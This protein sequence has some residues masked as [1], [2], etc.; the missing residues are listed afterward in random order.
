MKIFVFRKKLWTAIG[1]LVMACAM[2]WAVNYPASVGAAATARQL[3]I[4]SVQQEEGEKKISISFD[5]AWGADDTDTLISIL[6]QHNV[7][8]T[9]FVVGDW[10]DTYPDEVKKL[11]DA[12]HEVMNHSD[13]HPYFTQCSTD[14][15]IQ[16]IEN[17]NDKIE[18][19]TGVR[20]TLIR[21]PYG[22]YNDSVV[23][24][25]RSLDMEPIQWSVDSLDWQDSATADSIYQR[26]TSQVQPGS[27]I[28]CH[29]DAEYTPDALASI[30]ETLINEGYTF[31]PI[32]ELILDGPYTI[33][34][35]GMQ[36]PA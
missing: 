2:L 19:I 36:I 24:T 11:S 21:C 9:F 10:V 7:R 23:N 13:S 31:V 12:G 14:T 32:S 8:A 34:H 1:C 22:D 30:L 4:Y 6:G 20:P 15:V 16:E 18:A 28:L 35:T 3:P 29:N 33:D 26:V 25:V 17:C 5:A 27:I